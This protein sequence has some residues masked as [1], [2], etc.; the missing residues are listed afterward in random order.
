MRSLLAIQLE[1]LLSST[2]VKG[3]PIVSSDGALTLIGYIDR[4]E[5]RHVLGE[6]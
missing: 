4:S 6:L 5:I 3:F 2:N 1:S